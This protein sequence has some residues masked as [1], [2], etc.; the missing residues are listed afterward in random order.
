MVVDRD[1]N[2]NIE[3]CAKQASAVAKT[4]IKFYW[5]CHALKHF[6]S[7]RLTSKYKAT[8]SIGVTVGEIT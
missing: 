3:L 1:T 5:N 8:R 4:S 7:G 6:H 2:Q